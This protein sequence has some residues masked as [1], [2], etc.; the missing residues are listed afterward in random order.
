MARLEA[1][2]YRDKDGNTPIPPPPGEIVAPQVARERIENGDY[3]LVI[4]LPLQGDAPAIGGEDAPASTTVVR[5]LTLEE[6]LAGVV[7][8]RETRLAGSDVGH[9]VVITADGLELPS[10]GITTNAAC[11][12]AGDPRRVR[13]LAFEEDGDADSP[14]TRVRRLPAQRAD[15]ARA[16]TFKAVAAAQP[17]SF[18]A[19]LAA[20]YAR[21]A[22]SPPFEHG[23]T[24]FELDET[25]LSHFER[26]VAEEP[27]DPFLRAVWSWLARVLVDKRDVTNVDRFLAPLAAAH[28]PWSELE[29]AVAY[30]DLEALD[31]QS[32]ARKLEAVVAREASNWRAWFALGE[33]R[34]ILGQAAP[35]VQAFGRVCELLP[36]EYVLR[37]RFAMAL[38]RVDAAAGRKLVAELLAEYPKDEELQAYTGPDAPPP[39]PKTY[40]PA[41]LH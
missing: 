33:A 34:E 19:G 14:W 17:G 21:Q 2:L 16:S 15:A 40:T 18:S 37:R 41:G 20:Y 3:D 27:L 25:A 13:V 4:A 5:W 30:A 22:A 12:P 39:P 10:L 32:A 29:I 23:L 35:A 31:A 28:A 6:P 8:P 38:T 26:A 11:A 9:A 7:N 36:G 1:E 24:R